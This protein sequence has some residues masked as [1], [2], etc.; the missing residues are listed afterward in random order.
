MAK[1]RINGDYYVGLDIGTDSVGWA[2]SDTDYKIMKFNGK[3][4]WGVRL[5]DGGNTA[6]ERRAFRT[7]R[8]R[9]ART[10]DR[11]AFLQL[12]FDNAVCQK[13][14]AFFQR[15]KESNLYSEDKTVTGKYSLFNDE[16]YSDADFYKEFPTIY[17]LRKALLHNEKEYDV[18]LVYLAVHHLI[19]HRGHFLFDNF[20]DGEIMSFESAWKNF[21]DYLSYEYDISFGNEKTEE[22][23]SI[24]CDRT[25]SKTAKKTEIIKIFE[26][27]QDKQKSALIAML[28]GCSAKLAEVYADESCRDMEKTA[29]SFDGGFEND[30]PILMSSLGDRYQ[31][32]ALAKQIYDCAVL[33]NILNGSRYLCEAKVAVYE[34]HKSD[35]ALLKRFVNEYFPEEKY[36]I[37]SDTE[38]KL[39]NYAAYSKHAKNPVEQT[40]IQEDFCK[41]LKSVFKNFQTDDEEYKRML[42]EIELGTFMPKAVSKDNGVIPMQLNRIELVKILDNAKQYLP[43]LS[44]IDPNCGKSAAQKIIDIFDFRIPYYVGPLNNNCKE[45]SWVVRQEGKIYPWNFNEIVDAEASAENFIRRMTAKCTYLPMED[46]L[47]KNSLLYTKY[48]VLNEINNIRV[49][50]DKISVSLKQ[51]LYNH[52]LQSGTKIGK[53][54]LTGFFKSNGYTSVEI[55]GVDQGRITNTLKPLKDLERF[56]LT[57]E[58]KEEIIKSITIF[59]DDKKLLKNRLKKYYSSKLDNDDIASISKLK[60]SGW[61]SLSEKLLCGIKSV[62]KETGEYTDIIGALWE[63]NDNLMQLLSSAYSFTEA[64]QEENKSL[65]LGGLKEQVENLYV[66][67]K[68]KR[69]IYQTMQLLQE[70]VKI[71]GKPPKKIFVEVARNPDDV[72]QRTKSRRQQLL[73]LYKDCRKTEPELCTLLESKTDESEFRRDRLFLYF[74]QKGKCV[75]TG[76]TIELTDLYNTQMWDID[77]IYPQSK[78]KDDS[79]DNRVLV[80]KTYNNKIKSNNYP[81]PH[82]VR[83]KMYPLWKDLYDHKM[84]SQKKYSRLMRS[85]PLTDDELDGFIS[86]QIVELNQSVKAV[87]GLIY[88]IYPKEQTEVVYSKARFVSE[89]RQEYGYVKCRE[90]NDLHHAKDAYLNIVVGNVYNTKFTHNRRIFIKDLQ[91][92]RVSLNHMFAYDVDGAWKLGE[93]STKD[94]VD[95]VMKKN[96][97]TVTRYSFCQH[98]GLFKQ[99][100]LKKGKGQVPQKKNSPISDISKYG[101][102]NKASSSFFALAE[103]KNQKG[104]LTK[105]FIPVD[106]YKLQ[107]YEADPIGYIRFCP[108][109]KP[110]EVKNDIRIIIPKIKY[111]ALLSVNGFR[112]NIS[113][114]SGSYLICK[115]AVQ[116]VLSENMEKYMKLISNYLA[117]CA[118]QKKPLEVTRFDKITR[119]EN[120]DLYKTLTDKLTGT[121]YSRKFS[122]LGEKLER[123]HNVFSELSLYEQ[124]Y[125]INQIVLILRNNAALGDLTMIGEKRNAGVTKLPCILNEKN[126]IKLINQSIT[127]MFENEIEL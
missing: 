19:K 50:G 93:N 69:P 41:F 118:E 58:E 89:F 29:V 72:K 22:I 61:G 114:K 59:G 26:C 71:N 60:Y 107:E 73:D 55:T 20:A 54:Q 9:T 116:L 80:D 97:I 62:I 108:Y 122:A 102:Y 39:S 98:G 21:N 92:G 33:D 46:V 7:N 31:M 104:K 78:V 103:Y 70:I 65:S 109:P 64:I 121:V 12:I 74:T 101:G 82:D 13:D 96:N 10:R 14:E 90:L 76:K 127:G 126:S 53:K 52:M 45:H 124:C 88:N 117:K 37:F 77:H 105:A 110:T 115:P 125:V 87:C 57:Y 3:A 15:L 32:I 106:N 91:T 1:K 43:F 85:T 56:N 8:R 99:T 17:H 84:I 86:R 18:R 27:K 16:Q 6:A 119:E 67:P 63:T 112:M 2:V 40:C 23:K 5:F 68:I 48:M 44:E 79:L 120:I 51:Q 35:L 4:M 100:I 24:M 81:L 75:Y 123:K 113:A 94:T 25:I 83:E 49:N 38:H 30:E 28:C 36:R 111:N 42:S 11:I 66:S 34:K 47:P 95:A